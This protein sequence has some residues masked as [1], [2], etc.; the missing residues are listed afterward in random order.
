MMGRSLIGCSNDHVERFPRVKLQNHCTVLYSEG[1]CEGLKAILP[2]SSLESTAS[3][4]FIIKFKPV[5]I[6]YLAHAPF[7]FEY[8][9]GIIALYMW[10]IIQKYK[11]FHQNVYFC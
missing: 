10:Q 8:L 2:M 6:D 9:M 5:P 3:A 7:Q 1:I 4:L 11:M